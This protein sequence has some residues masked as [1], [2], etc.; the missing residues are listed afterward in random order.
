MT[1]AQRVAAY[2]PADARAGRVEEVDELVS[3]ER[4]PPPNP[5]LRMEYAR[6]GGAGPVRAEPAAVHFAGLDTENGPLIQL[7]RLVNASGNPVRMHIMHPQTPHFT[8]SVGRNGAGKRGRVMPGMA[9]EILS[10]R[11]SPAYSLTMASA[12]PVA[13]EATDSSIPR[14]LVSCWINSSI[15]RP[16]E[17]MLGAKEYHH[18]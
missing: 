18:S 1:A 16:F 2:Y 3:H 8:I 5:L 17:R 15:V 14:L 13:P 4:P 9:E 10:N 7:V 6:L 12:L 11:S